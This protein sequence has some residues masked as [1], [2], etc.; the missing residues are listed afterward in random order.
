MP[1]MIAPIA[2]G[3]GKAAL[4]GGKTALGAGKVAASGLGKLGGVASKASHLGPMA[5]SNG[6]MSAISNVVSPGLDVGGG[7]MKP[8]MSAMNSIKGILGNPQ[9]QRIGS[10]L[11]S[12]PS[13][14]QQQAPPAIP[15]NNIQMN[16]LTSQS[17]QPYQSSFQGLQ[18][19]PNQSLYNSYLNRNQGLDS[20]RRY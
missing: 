20:F 16:P 15:Q 5:S 8:G 7:M 14:Q 3:I 11:L 17:E 4:V 9:V 6:P 1:H 13:M 18:I 19:N 10:N 12:Q 2:M